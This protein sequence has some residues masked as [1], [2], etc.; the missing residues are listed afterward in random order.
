MPKLGII[1]SGKVWIGKIAGRVRSCRLC[2]LSKPAQNTQL[3]LLASEVAERTMD[4]GF[5]DYVGPFPR[6]KRGN[7]MLLVCVDAFS[8]FV[9]L[10]P[11]GKAT[12]HSTI[13]ALKTSIFQHFGFPKITV[14]DN[15]SQFTSHMFKRMCFGHGIHHVTTS[16][17][18]PQPSH[19]ERLN[20]NL[21]SALI[22]FHAHLQ[23]TCDENLRWLQ[24]SFN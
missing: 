19:A 11:L 5:I 13:Q 6:S 4:K 17:Y 14:S 8:K 20:R 21:R 24:L 2:S 1:S 3:G 10:L 22:A 16:P 18:Y 15:G 12:A 9:W 23:T 7:S